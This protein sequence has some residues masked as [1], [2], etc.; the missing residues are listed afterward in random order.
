[1]LSGNQG[2]S[3]VPEANALYQQAC[4]AEYKED[5]QTAVS[6]LLQALNLSAMM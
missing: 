6:K 3:M 1:M 5:Y 2:F 4:S